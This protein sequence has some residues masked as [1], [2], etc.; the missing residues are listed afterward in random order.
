MNSPPTANILPAAETSTKNT[1]RGLCATAKP[2]LTN[3]ALNES[4]CA[5]GCCGL[6]TAAAAR[7]ASGWPERS[8]LAHA[9][10]WEYDNKML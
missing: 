7:R 5:R 10:L 9:F 1:S 2:L 4:C 3:V 6:K 8:K